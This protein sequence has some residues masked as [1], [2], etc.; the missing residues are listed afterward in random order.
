[1]VENMKKQVSTLLSSMIISVQLV[2]ISVL[3]SVTSP[4]TG[5][6]IDLYMNTMSTVPGDT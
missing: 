1:M 5:R 3:G 2:I 6:M 4:K